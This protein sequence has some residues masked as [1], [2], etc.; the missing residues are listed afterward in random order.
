MNMQ[1]VKDFFRNNERAIYTVLVIALLV[2]AFYF[3]QGNK[4]SAPAINEATN[5]ASSTVVS[6]SDY[7]AVDNQTAGNKVIIKTL[8]LPST[9]WVA[10]HEIKDG[11]TSA[12]LGAGRFRP[13]NASGEVELVV[14]NTEAGKT[15][16]AVVHT[17]DGD[18]TFSYKT[19]V[20]FVVDGKEVMATFTA[21]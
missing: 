2:V 11:V 20:P 16:Q 4:V 13:E 15:Y 17:D 19:D 12:I 6:T 5:T 14:R 21:Q 9:S 10:V 1:T 3:L 8:A 7:I 18:D